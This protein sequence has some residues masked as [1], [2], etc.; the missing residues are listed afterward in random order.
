MAQGVGDGAEGDAGSLSILRWQRNLGFALLQGV[1]GQRG[2]LEIPL[3]VL[4]F[5][6]M[7]DFYHVHYHAPATVRAQ[8]TC[9]VR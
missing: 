6:M 7:N 2:A 3:L 1:M 4:T 8:S 5:A 9:K